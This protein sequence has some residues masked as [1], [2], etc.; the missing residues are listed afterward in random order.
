MPCVEEGDSSK[1]R[2]VAASR[3]FWHRVCIGYVSVLQADHSVDGNFDCKPIPQ[4][5]QRRH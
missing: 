1:I 3:V 2:F 5:E 4:G